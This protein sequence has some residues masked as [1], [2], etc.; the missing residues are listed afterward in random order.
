MGLKFSVSKT[1]AMFSLLYANPCQSAL[2]QSFN[3]S[4]TSLGCAHADMAAYAADAS[5]AWYN[6]AGMNR[7][8]DGQIAVN[9]SW[10]FSNSTFQGTMNYANQ[11][12]LYLQQGDSLFGLTLAAL[13]GAFWIPEANSNT[14]TEQFSAFAFLPFKNDCFNFAVGL[15]I[16]SP[17]NFET[18]WGEWNPI[19][20]YAD[21]T[22]FQS[23]QINPSIAIELFK[24][25]SV[26]VGV[27]CDYL[28]TD[29]T[30]NYLSSGARASLDSWQWTWNAGVL[31]EF[32]CNTRVGVTYRPRIT[33]RL[34]GE[35]NT[36]NVHGHAL[37]TLELPDTVSAGIYH[38]VSSCWSLMANF[39]W[40]GWNRTH[41]INLDAGLGD[42]FGIYFAGLNGTTVIDFDTSNILIPLEP[43]NSYLVSVGADYSPYCDWIVRF[44]LAY[45]QS[46]M[47]NETRELRF[48]D[49]DRYMAS[50]GFRHDF[51]DC[52]HLDFGYAFTYQP[53]TGIEHN[54]VTAVNI[55]GT[56]PI[57]SGTTTYPRDPETTG[58]YRSVKTIQNTLAL[59]VSWKFN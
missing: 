20:T 39:V 7:F 4:A 22:K 58:I 6:P 38:Q 28:K 25:F 50:F 14:S 40:T 47:T 59:Q 57:E 44:G 48:L 31:Y 27:G 52:V 9:G 17:W 2:F 13:E 23:V 18:I 8:C 45:E 32:D 53:K 56:T 1:L 24:G 36:V 51:S 54:P 16:A 29:Y 12:E 10:M 34:T 5:T 21:K 46:P 19:T 33:H 11:E 41:G 30:L 43:K 35:S 15:A 55:V 3:Q 49:A 42:N 26:A 37:S